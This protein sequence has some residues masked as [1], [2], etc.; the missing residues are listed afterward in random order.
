M[1]ISFARKATIFDLRPES[2]AVAMPLADSIFKPNPSRMLKDLV[3]SPRSLK[4]SVPSVNTPSTSNIASRMRCA[5]AIRRLFTRE[6]PGSMDVVRVSACSDDLRP[7]EIVHVQ[8]AYQMLILI[9]HQQLGDLVLFHQFGR[10]CSQFIRS[11]A[12]RVRLHQLAHAEA[13]QIA[14]RFQR[15]A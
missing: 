5:R 10:L 2:S 11:E 9:H 15:A 3:S 6:S 1:P 8:R 7:H 12:A 4:W 14:A 13:A